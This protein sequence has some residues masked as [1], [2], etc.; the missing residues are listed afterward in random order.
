[1][2]LFSFQFWGI[3]WAFL[4][5]FAESRAVSFRLSPPEVIKASWNARTFLCEDLNTDGLND[6]IF[7]NLD[8]SRIE[9]L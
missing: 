4:C 2:N 9:I 8:R 1:M 3:Y 6:F 5:A 7:F